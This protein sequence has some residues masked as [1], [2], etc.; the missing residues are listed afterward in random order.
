MAVEGQRGCEQRLQ[1]GSW[2]ALL[3]RFSR[4]RSSELG[5]G[6]SVPLSGCPPPRPGRALDER[7]GLPRAKDVGAL[8]FCPVSSESG[9]SLEN[10]ESNHTVSPEG[11]PRLCGFVPWGSR[12]SFGGGG[13]VWRLS[14]SGSESDAWGVRSL[15]SLV[16][17]GLYGFF[18]SHPPHT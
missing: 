12:V 14:D 5:S 8:G 18:D 3:L 15:S 7:E 1:A 9:S 6:L 16:F 10:E 4:H 11:L 13:R 2:G 17:L